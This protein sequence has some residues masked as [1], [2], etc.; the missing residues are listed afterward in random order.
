MSEYN[1]DS[2]YYCDDTSV[3]TQISGRTYSK[4]NDG[5]AYCFAVGFSSF[6]EIM[7]VSKTVN[8]TYYTTSSGQPTYETGTFTF[9]DETWYYKRGWGFSN[10]YGTANRIIDVR[11]VFD[12]MPSTFEDVALY[13]TTI[14][15]NDA[16]ALATPKMTSNTTP[17]GV[18]S[19]SSRYDSNYEA[20]YAFNQ[21]L[22]GD[23]LTWATTNALPQWI[24]YQFP[25]PVCIQR[26]II[27]NRAETNRRAIETF[28]F[29]GSNDGT[30]WTD[31]K[32]CTST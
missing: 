30:S 18:V 31:L 14:A 2:Q 9:Q 8:Y 5:S 12:T 4:L 24:Q 28:I 1:I 25:N 21:T 15:S 7:V 27:I 17:S 13:C 23:P 19:C 22:S 32:T 16:Y 10:F 6:T 3:F 11:Y 29:Q 20:W 26:V